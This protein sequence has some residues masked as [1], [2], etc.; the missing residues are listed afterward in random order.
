MLLHTSLSLFDIAN[1]L[2]RQL[3]HPEFESLRAMQKLRIRHLFRS[4][5]NPSNINI[6]LFDIT[7]WVSAVFKVLCGW[8]SWHR[9]EPRKDWIVPYLLQNTFVLQSCPIRNSLW[10]N[11]I[12]LGAGISRW[13]VT[14]ETSMSRF[15]SGCRI[16]L[17]LWHRICCSD[18]T[19]MLRW[20]ADLVFELLGIYILVEVGHQ[21]LL[22]AKKRCLVFLTLMLYLQLLLVS[23][24]ENSVTVWSGMS[25]DKLSGTGFFREASKCGLD[26]V[27]L[28]AGSTQFCVTTD[29]P[30]KSVQSLIPLLKKF[31]NE[32][33]EFTLFYEKRWHRWVYAGAIFTPFLVVFFCLFF[34][35]QLI[36]S[37]IFCFLNSD[38][39]CCSW[40]ANL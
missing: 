29:S 31:S 11:I 35:I 40:E 30:R 20:S 34:L 4:E 6:K 7:L 3:W 9:D 23:P 37:I 36:S 14:D 33:W 5:R 18:K 21:Q 32:C 15:H 17:L 25:L 28:A 24:L 22:T 8:Q 10:W 12:N 1:F 16:A 27:A 38:V 2:K 26:I 39:W 19:N 13:S